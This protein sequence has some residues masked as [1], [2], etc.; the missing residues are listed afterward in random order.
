LKRF[1][2]AVFRQHGR[3]YGVYQQELNKAVEARLAE[4]ETSAETGQCLED[5][6]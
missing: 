5:D 3:L 6:V 2:E 4:L 1:R